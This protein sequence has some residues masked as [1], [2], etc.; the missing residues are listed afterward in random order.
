MASQN[1]ELKF[2]VIDTIQDIP[3][4]EWDSLFDEKLIESYDYQKTLEDA[5]LK[6]FS[7]RYLL[8][9][10]TDNTV[11]ILPF[12][13][14]SFAIDTLIPPPFHRIAT[15]FK[16]ALKMK[17]I[18]LGSPTTEEFN[19]G[20][21]KQLKPET[22][23]NLA[24]EK[25][26]AY[27]KENKIDSLVFY[28]LSDKYKTLAQY[29]IS[30]SYIRME[31]LPT[32]MIKIEAGSIEEYIQSLSKN[33]RKDIKRKL[34]KSNEL[35]RLKTEIREDIDDII[36]EV[37]R[38]YLNN[39]SD[40]DVHFEILTAEFFK[41][42]CRNM[43][44]VAKYFI[45]YDQNN[46]IVAFNLCLIKDDLFIDKFIGFDNKVAQ[47]YHLYFITFFHNLD[48]CIK[49]KIHYYQP[50]NTDYHPKVRLGQNLSP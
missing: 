5:R 45:T 7:F 23:F 24:L 9:K 21:A 10:D 31:S 2:S 40:S 3:R 44:G 32:T 12:F 25:I 30:K 14:M 46:K 19:M 41:N 29:L 47:E 34:K 27:A 26:S 16:N 39:F 48:W 42:I 13:I 17:V 15:M 6:E 22:F 49:N 28:N 38:L 43:P 8:A 50:G 4:S 37:Y 33:M 35:V 11:A 36:E 20:L 18:F 1:P